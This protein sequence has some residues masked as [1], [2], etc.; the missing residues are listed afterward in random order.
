[1]F[2]TVVSTVILTVAHPHLLHA[3]TVVATELVW[4]T[5]ATDLQLMVTASKFV[6]SVTA[7]AFTVAD[8]LHL[9]A[10]R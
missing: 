5:L 10:L 2:V 1:L 3:V 7:V 4:F 6:R 8:K 9:D